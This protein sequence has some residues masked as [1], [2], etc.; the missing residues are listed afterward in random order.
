MINAII[1]AQ[2]SDTIWFVGGYFKHQVR[3]WM[4][5]EVAYRETTPQ[6]VSTISISRSLW[7]SHIERHLTENHHLS[8][9]APV[10]QKCGENFEA[11]TIPKDQGAVRGMEDITGGKTRLWS[12]SPL[13]ESHTQGWDS[14]GRSLHKEGNRVEGCRQF[15]HHRCWGLNALGCNQIF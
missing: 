12:C 3:H 1:F 10:P 13:W 9:G 14:M 5:K 11:W 4:R 6:W 7:M 8:P 15:T 2:K